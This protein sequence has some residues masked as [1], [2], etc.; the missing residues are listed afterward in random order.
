MLDEAD[1]HADNSRF[2]RGLS[3]DHIARAARILCQ[4]LFDATGKDCRLDIEHVEII[5]VHFIIGVLGQRVSLI[6]YCSTNSL[7]FSTGHFTPDR[8]KKVD[9]NWQCRTSGKDKQ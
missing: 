9:R 4:R 3:S 2:I 8:S 1:Y 7:Q 6:E 5:G